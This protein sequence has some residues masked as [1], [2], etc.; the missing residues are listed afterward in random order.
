[1][2]KTQA[3][4]L[5]AH[6]RRHGYTKVSETEGYLPCPICRARVHFHTRP[7]RPVTA[8][9]MDAAMVGHLIDDCSRDGTP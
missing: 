6:A 9:V 2:T 3:R 7:G 1:M 4:Q 8:A 5:A